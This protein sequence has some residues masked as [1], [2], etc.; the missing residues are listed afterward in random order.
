MILEKARAKISH[1]LGIIIKKSALYETAAWGKTDQPSFYNQVIEVKSAITPVDM[2]AAINII[3]EELGR[4]RREKWGERVI[5]ID[6]LYYSNRVISL[7]KLNIPHPGI[8]DRRFTLVPLVEIAP[9]FLHP[10]L[11]KT[12][13]QLLN[14]CTDPL[15][16]ERMV[17]G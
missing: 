11:K 12:N 8:Q 14:E 2:L 13:Q 15:E 7:E 10:F 6:I 16:V 17:N 3:E 9:D 4:V 1:R 5:D